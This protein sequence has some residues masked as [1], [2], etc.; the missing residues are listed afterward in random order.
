MRH[1]MTAVLEKSETYTSNFDTE[2]YEVGWASEARWFIRIQKIAGEDT[3]L[4]AY[5]QISPDGLFWCD[6][7]SEPIVMP[8][9]GLYSLALREFGQWLR[10]RCE[11]AGKSSSVMVLIYL[12]MKE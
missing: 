12:A 8:K 10:L 11:L 2:P 7:G 9:E 4:R 3:V 1:S 6:E 5:P